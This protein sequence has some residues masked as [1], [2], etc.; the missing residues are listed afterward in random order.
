[1]I[2]ISGKIS[3]TNDYLERFNRAE[4]KLIDLGYDVINPALVNSMLPKNTTYQQYMKMSLCM[5]EM[6]DTIYMIDGWKNSPGAK[7]E[8][9]YAKLNNYLIIYD[10]IKKE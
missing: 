9:E 8:H 2:Y 6:C 5:L 3:G 10:D 7:L 1:M 4:S